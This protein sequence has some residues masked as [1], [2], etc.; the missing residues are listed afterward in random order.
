M[1]APLIS[2]NEVSSDATARILSRKTATALIAAGSL[3]LYSCSLFAGTLDDF[4][5]SALQD[6][7]EKSR[8]NTSHRK[9]CDGG[10]SS[11]TDSCIVDIFGYLLVDIA[12]AGIVVGGATSWERT[13]N[14]LDYSVASEVPARKLGDV[15][16]P[17]TR[18]DFAYQDIGHGVEAYDY[19]AEWGYGPAAIQF[20]QTRYSEGSPRDNLDLT[21][22][23]GLYRMSFGSTVEIDM[24]F[25]GLTMHGNDLDSRFSFTLPILFHPNEF[26]GIELRP[27]WADNIA[28]YDIALLL[29]QHFSSLK[30]GYRWVN[31]PAISLHGPYAGLSAH[32]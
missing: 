24:G 3:L 26:V 23:Y 13:A 28:D 15:L 4:E 22:I 32:F 6:K 27:A 1:T 5:K 20:N 11:H 21:R 14:S 17:F 2:G 12:G 16:L 19:R 7:P 9:D 18:L 10:Y 29:S 30:I 31:S 25:G 8:Q